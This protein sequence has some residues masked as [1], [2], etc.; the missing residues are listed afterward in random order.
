MMMAGYAMIAF[1]RDL[2]WLSEAVLALR[3]LAERTPFGQ[4]KG[5]NGDVDGLEAALGVKRTQISGRMARR[6]A[7]MDA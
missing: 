1:L 3:Y 4:G 5:W 6:R 2:A 7:D